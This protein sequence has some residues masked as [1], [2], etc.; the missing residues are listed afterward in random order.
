M[1]AGV[2]TK[3]AV[4]CVPSSTAVNTLLMQLESFEAVQPVFELAHKHLAEV[5]SAF[6]FLDAQS[7]QLALKHVQGATNPFSDVA[8]MHVLV[9]TSGAPPPSPPL[10]MSLARRWALVPRV[11]HGITEQGLWPGGCSSFSG[12]RAVRCGAGSNGA[13]D[14]EKLEAFVEACCALRGVHDAVIAQDSQQ[15][16]NIWRL[17]EGI[18][19]GVIKHGAR[20]HV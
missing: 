1:F 6:E 20:A 15:T 4:K 19:E 10:Q 16:A 8:A 9:E 12:Y 7:M 13:H 2:I 3:A 5:L 14:M 18:P 11:I 17:R